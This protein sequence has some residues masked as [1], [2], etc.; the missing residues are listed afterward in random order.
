MRLLVTLAML[1]AAVGSAVAEPHQSFGPV[2]DP[3]QATVR[4]DVCQY[5]FQDDLPGQGWTLGLGQQLGIHCVGPM[6][7]TRVGFYVE[8]L[9]TPGAVDIVIR[10]GGVEVQRTAVNPVEG[11]NEFDIP[12]IAVADPCI[13]LCPQGDFWSVTGEDTTNG[14]FGHTYWSNSCECT[15]EFTDNNL[16]IWAVYDGA[17]PA[18]PVSWS[19]LRAL[20]R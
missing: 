8:F 17:V 20:Y 4:E 18:E 12:D 15:N 7:I 13:M 14:P 6:T 5:G 2:G 3:W 1:A 9:V 10:D 11:Q 19:R 16:T